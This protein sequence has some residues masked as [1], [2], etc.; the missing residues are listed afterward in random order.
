MPVRIMAEA[1]GLAAQGLERARAMMMPVREEEKVSR[2]VIRRRWRDADVDDGAAG[3]SRRGCR[4]EAG[5]AQTMPGT[6][7]MEE[8]PAPMSAATADHRLKP[9]RETVRA[10][11]CRREWG[12]E[13]AWWSPAVPVWCAWGRSRGPFPDHLGGD[14]GDAWQDGAAGRVET[15]YRNGT[16][17]IKASLL[18][19]SQE[20]G[21]R[22][23]HHL[24]VEI[25]PKLPEVF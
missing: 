22:L 1:G 9:W 25:M 24:I 6:V 12:S 3:S 18:V 20:T 5:D 8:S 17:T 15:R 11:R 14:G 23:K 4:T 10:R 16:A 13:D 21:I 7:I 19:V 2:A